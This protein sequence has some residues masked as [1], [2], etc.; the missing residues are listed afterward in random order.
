MGFSSSKEKKQKEKPK[1]SQNLI[2]LLDKSKEKCI[3]DRHEIN[4]E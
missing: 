2:N 1:T 3:Q 4:L